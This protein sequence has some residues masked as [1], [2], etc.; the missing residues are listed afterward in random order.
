MGKEFD[1]R[2][3]CHI[4]FNNAI[5]RDTKVLPLWQCVIKF[6]LRGALDIIKLRFKYPITNS[7]CFIVQSQN[8]INTLYPVSAKLTTQD[9]SFVRIQQMPF[10]WSFIYSL[11]YLG[12]FFRFY[13][14]T[15]IEEKH[16]IKYSY[17][18]FL[19]A[20]GFYEVAK[21][22]YEK[23]KKLK[24]VI[25][26]NDH[27][28]PTRCLI[29]MANENGLTTMYTQHASITERF[30]PLHF[31][32]SFL[33]GQESFEKYQ[34]IGDISGKVILLGSPRFDNIVRRTTKTNESNTIGIALGRFESMDKVINLCQYI[35]D[36]LD[37][38]IVI[39]P[40]PADFPSFDSSQFSKLGIELSDSRQESSFSFLGRIS[41]LIAN[42]SGIHLDSALMG[43]PSVMVNLSDH[44]A[45]DWYGFIKKGMIK[46]IESKELLLQSIIKKEIA[47]TEIVKYY[48]AAFNTK[49]DGH[50]AE[51]IASFIEAGKDGK[52]LFLKTAFSEK[53]PGVY[54][55]K[56]C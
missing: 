52:E 26:A 4:E 22:F 38:E 42:M 49:F 37:C 28:V 21:R 30:P 18:Y 1:Y 16:D 39:R 43:T 8:N 47:P 11:P 3:I 54:E 9:Y 44:P 48:Y 40:H 2:A 41:F 23:N 17:N 31:S 34:R 7:I 50:I 15:S 45:I 24:C 51:T 10:A 29:E 53:F 14:S 12:F 6:F 5:H 13:K 56:M 46:Q 55:I 33:D 32:Y 27:T 25:F 20:P 19:S 36:K 35:K